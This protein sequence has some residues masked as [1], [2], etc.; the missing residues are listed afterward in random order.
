MGHDQ[1]K[2][3]WDE[4]KK[5]AFYK[6]VES[7]PKVKPKDR[8]GEKAEIS[9]WSYALDRLIEDEFDSL[10]TSQLKKHK[11]FTDIPE[12]LFNKAV[13]TW[14]RYLPDENWKEMKKEDKPRAFEFLHAL[15]RLGYPDEFT[16]SSLDTYYSR[17][18]KIHKNSDF[19]N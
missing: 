16:Y 10:T 2:V 12:S 15:H 17:G 7:L 19:Q 1:G 3:F 9:F 8:N 6:A 5:A 4:E 14:R 13:K 11:G 18:K